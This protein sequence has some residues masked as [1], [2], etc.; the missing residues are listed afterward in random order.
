[1]VG[2]FEGDQIQ[3]QG[4]LKG[5]P[6]EGKFQ[7]GD[8]ITGMNGRKFVAGEHL[9]YLIGNAIIEAEKEE[10]AGKMTFQVWRDRNYAARFGKKDVTSV[11]VDKIFDEARDDNSLYEWKPEEERTKEVTKMNFDKFPVDPTTLEVDLKLRVFPAYSDTSP[12]D[13]PKTNQILEDAWKVLEQKI[14]GRSEEPAQ[15]PRRH[16]RG[17]GAR[18][19]GQARASQTRA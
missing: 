1:M 9:G 11:D 13:C 12:Y 10:N 17:D 15:R 6:A 8:V 19:I 2:G 5:S 18:S 4:T 14:R 7:V 16:H 3:V